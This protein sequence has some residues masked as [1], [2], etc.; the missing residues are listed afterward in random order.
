V[1]K[2]T[3][4]AC[5]RTP[6][7]SEV[8]TFATSTPAL[9]ELGT[10]LTAH[11]VTHIAMES[12]GVYWQPVFNVLEEFPLELLVVNAQQVKQLPGRKTDV[13]DA[14]WLADLL[15]HGLVRGSAIP[16]RARRELRELLR[17]RVGLLHQRTQV[18][19]RIQKLLEGAN[20]K[21]ASVV[22]NVV[23]VSGQS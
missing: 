5:I 10:W 7:A 13:K 20:L 3:V 19:Q 12:T 15:R 1:H 2:R 18:I 17:Y 14:E 23:G 8:R 4:V 16:D 6:T 21:L 11:G 22:S 9:R